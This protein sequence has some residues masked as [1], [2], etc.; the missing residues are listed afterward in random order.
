LRV[1]AQHRFDARFFVV[2]RN[3]EQQAGFRHADSV[4][5]NYCASNLGKR[6]EAKNKSLR[7]T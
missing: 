6:V 1:I 2:S 3:E 5:E 7:L 4:T